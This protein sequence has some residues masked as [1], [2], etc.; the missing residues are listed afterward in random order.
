MQKSCYKVIFCDYR[1]SIAIVTQIVC[2]AQRQ[3]HTTIMYSDH[4]TPSQLTT[5]KDSHHRKQT[6][7]DDIEA[8]KTVS[9]ISYKRSSSI[10]YISYL[11]RP[12]LVDKE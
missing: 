7:R 11:I 3:M 10:G 1:Y 9:G 6:N 5:L 2:S 4:V 12:T 8:K